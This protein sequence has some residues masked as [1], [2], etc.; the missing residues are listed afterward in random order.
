MYIYPNL[1]P[2]KQFHKV[3]W[4]RVDDGPW[5][6]YSPKQMIY[7]V[8]ESKEFFEYVDEEIRNL[9]RFL[10]GR[11][12]ATT[13]SCAGHFYE[14]EHFN[15]IYNLLKKQQD[16]IRNSSVVLTSPNQETINP[17]YQDPSYYIP[18]SNEEEFL[19]E[20][21]R[22][23]TKG[24]LGIIEGDKKIYKAALANDLAVERDKDITLLFEPSR[25]RE[26]K[27]EGWDK[28]GGVIVDAIA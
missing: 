25:E 21:I 14:R 19:G 6:Y 28:I 2:H 12:Y 20:V 4:L 8:E 16:K 23:Q 13:P 22:Y 3:Q 27:K 17:R 26:K 24:V 1:L 18:W 10:H 15:N 11:G 9:V 7:R 5:W